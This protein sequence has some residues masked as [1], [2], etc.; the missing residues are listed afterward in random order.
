M[1]II[2]KVISSL[3]E[4]GWADKL[5]FKTL[6]FTQFIT[7]YLLSLGTKLEFK[8]VRKQDLLLLSS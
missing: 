3:T 1:D 5:L 4:L 2:V 8:D 7:S 6:N